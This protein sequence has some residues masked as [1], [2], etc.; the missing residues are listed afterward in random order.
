[1]EYCGGYSL[2]LQEGESQIV[3]IAIAIVKGDGGQRFLEAA[4]RFEVLAELIQG[5][6]LEAAPDPVEL[7]FQHA[8]A[9]QHGWYGGLGALCKIFHHTVIPD[10]QRRLSRRRQGPQH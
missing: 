4:V 1:Y 10:D 9:C 3:E 7:L 2:F 5:D 6:K 8:A